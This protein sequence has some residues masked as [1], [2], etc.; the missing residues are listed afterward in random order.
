MVPVY[1]IGGYVGMLGMAADR[2]E[3]GVSTGVKAEARLHLNAEA[4]YPP[5]GTAVSHPATQWYFPTLGPS[6]TP[7]PDH[8]PGRLFGRLLRAAI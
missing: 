4:W 6:R 8:Q 7:A 2:G 3:K 5:L 1:P